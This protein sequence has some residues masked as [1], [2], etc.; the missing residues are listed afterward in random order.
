MKDRDFDFWLIAAAALA[1]SC[2]GSAV[3]L[4]L[5]YVLGG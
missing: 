1:S 3:T 2:L 4:F 5:L